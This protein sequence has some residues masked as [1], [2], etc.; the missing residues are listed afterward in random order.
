MKKALIIV[1]V[2][3]DFCQGGSLEVPQANQ[4]IPYINLLMQEN[5]YDQII[6]TQD[7]HPAGH[8]SFASSNRAQIG[9]T[10][11]L[12]GNAQFM[13]PDHCVQGSIGAEFHEDLNLEKVHH[14]VQKGTQ[15]N[16]D[17]YSGFWDN[18]KRHKTDLDD[19]L[20][21]HEIELVEICGLALDYCVKFTALDAQDLGYITCVHFQGTRAVNVQP[22]NGRD[23]IYQM[24]EKGVTFLG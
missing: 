2:Q 3:N 17:S 5:S 9:D 10:I 22:H 16:V 4:I 23:A 6:L 1:D 24:L 15:M 11:D 14:I 20:R 13:W 7:F 12:E 18:N 21:F 19:Y 8:K